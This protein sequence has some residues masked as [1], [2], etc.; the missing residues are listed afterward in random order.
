MTTNEPSTINADAIRKDAL[1]FK[2]KSV[3]KTHRKDTLDR[4]EPLR[5]LIT[6]MRAKRMTLREVANELTQLGFVTP[7]GNLVWQHQTVADAL[8]VLQLPAFP[9]GR[10]KAN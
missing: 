7:Q 4:W 2:Y 10:R 9:R 8:R 6:E 5:P 1:R 3:P